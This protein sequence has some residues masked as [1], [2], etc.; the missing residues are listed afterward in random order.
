MT[1][2]GYEGRHSPPPFV[3]GRKLMCL[4]A[5]LVATAAAAP[6]VDVDLRALLGDLVA[7]DTSNPPGN[8]AAAAKVAQS[9]LEKGGLRAEVIES[10]PGRAN[11]I[12]RMKG[13]GARK[14]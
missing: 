8:E 13:R 7:V 6:P 9:W 10:A 14:P 4:A 11:L 3:R 12:A 2:R 5:L 1:R